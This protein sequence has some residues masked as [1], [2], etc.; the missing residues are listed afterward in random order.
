M[1]DRLFPIGPVLYMDPKT[2]FAS[3][4]AFARGGPTCQILSVRVRKP[5]L[6]NMTAVLGKGKSKIEWLDI[7]CYTKENFVQ[8]E[9]F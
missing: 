4:K 9:K 1:P 2:P 8:L 6:H 3:S 7:S 5:E